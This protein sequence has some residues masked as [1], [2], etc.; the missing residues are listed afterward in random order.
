MVAA[1]GHALL[2]SHREAHQAA[3]GAF[4]R[5]PP[6][7]SLGRVATAYPTRGW[8]RASCGCFSCPRLALGEPEQRLPS[9]VSLRQVGI[10]SPT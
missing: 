6:E 3:D 4:L 2:A 1:G 7:V 10:V 8:P 5:L 9:E